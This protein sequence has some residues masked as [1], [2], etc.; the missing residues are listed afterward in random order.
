MKP[1]GL[2]SLKD[3]DLCDCRRTPIRKGMC[4]CKAKKRKEKLSKA[5]KKAYKSMKGGVRKA[6]KQNLSY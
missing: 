6:W 3:S 5:D 2:Q 1:Y 4:T